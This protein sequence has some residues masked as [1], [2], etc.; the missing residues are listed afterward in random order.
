[1]RATPILVRLPLPGMHL[2][3]GQSTLSLVGWHR[4]SDQRS[5]GAPHPGRVYLA[6]GAA[7]AVALLCSCG[8]AL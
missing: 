2:A 7:M 4:A 8:G 6:I 5:R 1:M 3:R